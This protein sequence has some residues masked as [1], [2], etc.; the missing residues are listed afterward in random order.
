MGKVTLV[1]SKLPDVARAIP[2]EEENGIDTSAQ[3]LIDLLKGAVWKRH[4][5]I[6]AS[7]KDH[8]LDPLLADIW[9]GN[10]GE[11]GFYSGFQEFGTI[12]QAARP[13]VAPT[14]HMFEPRF[15]VIMAEALRKAARA[16]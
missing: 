4:G 1:Y 10:I 8:S 2:R 16:G 11:I 5:Y 14:A 3:E 7:I 12:K 6:S 9:I 13:I 15:I